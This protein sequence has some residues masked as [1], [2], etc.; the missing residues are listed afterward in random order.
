MVHLIWLKV[1][2]SLENS[3]KMVKCQFHSIPQLGVINCNIKFVFLHILFQAFFDHFFLIM[4]LL[5]AHNTSFILLD[6]N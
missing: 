4:F 1:G 2:G 5:I 6:N 3:V